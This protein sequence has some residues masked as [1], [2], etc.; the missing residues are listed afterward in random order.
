MSKL[1][2]LYDAWDEGH[3]EFSLAFENLSDEDLWKRPH[4]KLLSVGE[5][6]AHVAYWEAQRCAV[7]IVSPLNDAAFRYYTDEVDHPV[8]LPMGTAEF[9]AEFKRVHAAAKD[10]IVAI[11]PSFE[12]RVPDTEDAT[13]GFY[14]QYAVFHAA[15]H[16]GQA[17][18]VRHLLG[19]TTTDN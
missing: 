1:Q 18:S 16:T 19:H 17:Y 8:T 5:N 7:E 2:L 3:F 9:L 10:S 15:Y 12:E 11:D 4:P 6:A 13:W 14:V